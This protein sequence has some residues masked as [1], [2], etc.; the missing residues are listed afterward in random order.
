[1]LLNGC[2]FQFYVSFCVISVSYYGRFDNEQCYFR[3]ENESVSRIGYL[4]SFLKLKAFLEV[5]FQFQDTVG[6]RCSS[7]SFVLR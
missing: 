7:E 6:G 1:M 4:L 2:H 5:F 3:Y